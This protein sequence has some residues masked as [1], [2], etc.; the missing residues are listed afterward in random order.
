MSVAEVNVCPSASRLGLELEV[1]LDDP[2]VDEGE[3]TGAVEVGVGVVVGRVAVGGPAG[4][5][6]RR[7]RAGRR[8]AGRQGGELGHRGRGVDAGDRLAGPCEP[9]RWRRRPPGPRRRSRTPGT[10]A[11]AGP[12]RR[13]GTA[14]ASPVTPMMPHMV[15]QATWASVGAGSSPLPGRLRLHLPEGGRHHAGQTRCDRGGLRFE[16]APRP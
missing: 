9:A 4:V 14:S 3:A 5:A 15:T 6:D 12:Q 7:V 8:G 11:G 10:R 2:V 13:S 16:H 1:V